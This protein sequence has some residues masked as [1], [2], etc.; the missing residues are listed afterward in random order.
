MPPR[1]STW[2]SG[3]RPSHCACAW[4]SCRRRI[5]IAPGWRRQPDAPPRR[6]ASADSR[7]RARARRSAFSRRRTIEVFQNPRVN[8]SPCRQRERRA[9][10]VSE[11][12]RSARLRAAA[13]SVPA[14]LSCRLRR[15][16]GSAAT[17]T[18]VRDQPHAQACRP[19][20][21]CRPSS[22]RSAS[23][24]SSA[25]PLAIHHPKR[26]CD[27][28][29]LA[30]VAPHDRPQGSVGF[31]RR[32]RRRSGPSPNRARQ[33]ETNPAENLFVDLVRQARRATAGMIGNLVAA[34]PRTPKRRIRTTPRCRAR[35]R[36]PRNSRPCACG[37]QHPS[38]AHSTAHDPRQNR[39][40]PQ[41]CL[42][43]VV[44]GVSRRT[45]H[46]SPGRNEVVLNPG[47]A[48]HRH[49][50]NSITISMVR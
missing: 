7:W 35:C 24:P 48:A 36:Y 20:A 38:S 1:S 40:R 3:A 45:R 26:I 25:L 18:P 44:E 46:L 34:R 32:G 10:P 43:P 42:Q 22:A 16:C 12:G 47:L 30:A 9:L 37:N 28:I 4:R 5:S 13:S 6:R 21:W 11:Q 33:R 39:S 49:R 29:G 2:A 23:G 14:K 41:Q 8:D 50:T 15:R 19:D 31:H 27:A 17:M